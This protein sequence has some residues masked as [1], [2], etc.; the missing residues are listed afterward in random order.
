MAVRIQ[1][2]QVL[3]IKTKKS[4]KKVT[5]GEPWC[6]FVAK[7]DSDKGRDGIAIFASN[8]EEAQWFTQAKVGN[9]IEV[10]KNSRKRPD[11]TWETRISVTAHI[12][13]MN[14][15]AVR[16]REAY[17]SFAEQVQG[18]DE[19][20]KDDYMDFTKAADFSDDQLPFN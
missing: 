18:T 19:P 14:A 11:G 16:D 20:T 4:G 10:G 9:I 15:T 6:M 12:D 3:D 2:G 17:K 1:K 13:G 7:G 8:P 5:T